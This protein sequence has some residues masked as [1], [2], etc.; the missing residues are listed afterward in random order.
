MPRKC[1]VCGCSLSDDIY[2]EALCL[3]CLVRDQDEQQLWDDDD[4]DNS[5][6][7]FDAGD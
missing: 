2:D 7:D 1:I 5:L 6:W 3:E 4:P